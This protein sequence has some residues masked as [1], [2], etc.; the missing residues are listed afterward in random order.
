[1]RG[2]TE[3]PERAPHY[4][5]FTPK[6]TGTYA[7]E[8]FSESN[9]DGGI[10]ALEIDRNLDEHYV[11]GHIADKQARLEDGVELRFFLEPDLGLATVATTDERGNYATSLPHGSYT[12]TLVRPGAGATSLRTNVFADRELNA[13]YSAPPA[14][15]PTSRPTRD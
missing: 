7:V 4:L 3:P 11:R 12:V 5:C 1:M 14:K 15:A 13:I 8:V 6:V 2:L 10:F 9:G